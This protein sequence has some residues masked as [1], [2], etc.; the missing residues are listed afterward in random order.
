M[1]DQSSQPNQL[2]EL[3]L[4][5]LGKVFVT[6]VGAWLVG[7]A[8]NMK[9]R[10]SLSEVKTVADAMMAARHLQNELN[11]PSATI[12]SVM[13]ALKDKHKKAYEFEQALGIKFPL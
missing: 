6:A 13:L 1:P 4:N 9:I 11:S 10:G 8:T 5:L 2:N 3:H 7:K 12:D